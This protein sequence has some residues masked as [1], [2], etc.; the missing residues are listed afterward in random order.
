[1]EVES[2]NDQGD[3]VSIIKVEPEAF[4]V[5]RIEEIPKNENKKIEDIPPAL[6][7]EPRNQTVALEVDDDDGL[8]LSECE[9]STDIKSE[10]SDD[11]EI[12]ILFPNPYSQ[13]EFI[14]P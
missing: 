2:E 11:D 10:A 4:C 5:T 6:E 3:L 1:M 7:N 8:M 13:D 9:T 14:E 12:E